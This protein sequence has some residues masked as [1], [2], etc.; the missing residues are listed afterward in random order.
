MWERPPAGPAPSWSE[1]REVA[2]R[3]ESLG[4]DT[5]WLALPVR[6]LR[7]HIHPFEGS[8]D[9]LC[10]FDQETKEP[11][12][13]TH[14]EIIYQRRVALLALAKE[15]GSVAEACRSFGISR[16]RYYEW[17]QRADRYG[18]EALMPKERRAPQMPSATPTHVVERLLTLAVLEPTIGCRQYADLNRPGFR[19][20]SLV[21]VTASRAGAD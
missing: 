6:V 9:G 4:A 19:D 13:V 7:L 12:T 8:G 5:V 18:L 10:G 20:Y 3:A 14:A 11:I 1:I 2:G 15:L 21:W 17:K 16:T